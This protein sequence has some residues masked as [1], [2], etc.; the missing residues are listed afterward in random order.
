MKTTG[1]VFLGKQG[2]VSSKD[3]PSNKQSEPPTIEQMQ[4][5]DTQ[6]TDA[7]TQLNNLAKDENPVVM[8]L[9]T[10]FPF[11]LF[12]TMLTI[13]KTK[14]NVRDTIFFGAS[15]I[16]SIMISDISSV[17][18]QSNLFFATIKIEKRMPPEPPMVISF[19]KKEEALQARRIIQGLIVTNQNKVDVTKV[20][21]EELKD[22]VEILGDSKAQRV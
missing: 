11:Q 14:V 16:R 5:Q 4:T 2:E 8:S 19:L 1:T 10:V 18:T 22:K 3:L 17:E 15:E 9:T 20:S 7:V 6:Q 13:E 21:T 12:P